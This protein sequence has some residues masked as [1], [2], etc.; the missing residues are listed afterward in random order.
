MAVPALPI[1]SDR[2]LLR[3]FVEDDLEA[4]YDIYRRDEVARHMPWEPR[5]R[6]MAIEMLERVVT[7]TSF[8]SKPH[9]IRLAAVLPASGTL[10]GDV[11]LTRTSAEHRQGEI[12][13]IIH[14]DHQRRGYATE[15]SGA[16]LRMGFE[17]LGL[18]RIIARADPRNLGS[19]G[20][21][22]RL[23]MR[24]EGHF[25]HNELIRGAW[26]DQVLYALLEEEWRARNQP[27]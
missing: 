27:C 4:F 7:L 21:M 25:H 17:E 1:H 16:V 8:D 12:G 3:P 10:I 11:G 15:A 14:P 9:V 2:L 26:S 19:M 5:T 20:V 18:H 22:E 6:E 23:G 13:F 24:R